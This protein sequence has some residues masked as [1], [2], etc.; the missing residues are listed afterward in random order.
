[1][2][3]QVVVSMSLEGILGV[4]FPKGRV[5]ILVLEDELVS[6]DI[7]KWDIHHSTDAGQ[8]DLHFLKC[9]C[10]RR[11]VKGYGD[12]VGLLVLRSSSILIMLLHFEQVDHHNCGPHKQTGGCTNHT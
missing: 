10:G 1:M 5:V 3:A 7:D 11:R 12:I 4:F 6:H 2:G 9:L 8:K